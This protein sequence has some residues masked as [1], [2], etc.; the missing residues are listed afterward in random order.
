MVDI[1]P[2]KG[3]TAT[4]TAQNTS[5]TLKVEGSGLEYTHRSV[6]R[7]WIKAEYLPY[8]HKTQ[9]SSVIKSQTIKIT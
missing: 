8:G 7:H 4:I 1:M 3:E 9:M 5:S 2:L 6:S